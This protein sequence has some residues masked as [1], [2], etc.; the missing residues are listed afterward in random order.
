MSQVIV[1]EP[2]VPDIA[3]VK[4]HVPSRSGKFEGPLESLHAETANAAATSAVVRPFRLIWCLL[5]GRF[6]GGASNL[7]GWHSLT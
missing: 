4:V 5:A 3:A 2:M 1:V 6:D 7:Q